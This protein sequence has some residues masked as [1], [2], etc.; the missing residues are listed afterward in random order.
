MQYPFWDLPFGYGILIAGVA[1]LH[2]FVSHFAIGGGLYLVVNER[3]ARKAGDN[4]RLAFLQRL[5]KLFALVTLVA[6]AVT[7]VGIWFC[8]GLLGPAAVAVLIHNFVWMWA[9][10]WTLFVIEITAAI[11]YYHGWKRMAPAD[12]MKIG[13]IYFWAAWLS[14]FVINGIITY[15]LTPGAW[16]AT[17]HLWAG[18]FNPT[19]WPSLVMRSFICVMLAGL[20]ALFVASFMHQGAARS[21]IVRQN[22]L[23]AICGLVGALPSLYWYWKMIPA[24]LTSSA[25]QN[26]PTPFVALHYSYWLAGGIAVL[27]VLFGLIIPRGMRVPVAG[28]LM[29]AGLGWFGSFEWFRESV[30]KPYIIVGYMYGNGLE[31]ADAEVYKKQG[32]LTSIAYR[33]GNDGADL[34]LHAC[35]SCHTMTGYKAL[36]PA[37]DGTD[38]AFVAAIVK[39]IRLLRGNMPPFL[40]TAAEADAVA[41][42]IGQGLDR[43]PISAIYGLQGVALGQKV[44]QIRCGKCHVM[45]GQRDITASL[46]GLARED[47]NNMLDSAADLGE[48]MPAFTGDQSERDA[49]IAYFLTLKAG[50]EK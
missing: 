46:A 33:S 28:L 2:A 27:I 47:Y 32:Y 49:L 26:L 12:H 3:S 50:G 7:G 1:I 16:L 25:L 48:G 38:P 40:G 11:L 8:I 19:F 4:E 42:H 35:R 9:S 43:R 18:F 22:A 34:F 24:A 39:S 31:L 14:L 21:R 36:K 5:S 30:R 17:G 20:Y 29:I 41:A 6:G 10:E 37:F 13:W 45:G 23:W 44:F 15:M